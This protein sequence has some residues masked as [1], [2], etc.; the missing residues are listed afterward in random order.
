L[1]STGSFATLLP[2]KLNPFLLK[3]SIMCDIFKVGEEVTFRALVDLPLIVEGVDELRG[4]VRCKYFDD[5]LLRFIKLTLPA[6]SLTYRANAMLST[7]N[8]PKKIKV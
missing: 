1:D 3:I 7:G 5:H 2:E 6:E 4:N 8:P